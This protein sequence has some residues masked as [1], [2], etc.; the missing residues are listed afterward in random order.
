M[1]HMDY[2][3]CPK[4]Q[5]Q[6]LIVRS[7]TI[8]EQ[9]RLLLALNENA[10]EPYRTMI[11]LSLFTDTRP[12]EICVLEYSKKIIKNNRISITKTTTRDINHK[13][14]LGKTTKTHV[15][16]QNIKINDDIGVY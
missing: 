3:I 5:K 8:Y 15:E 4:S 14:I 11:I 2:I 9:Q 6:A 12:G 1:N 13:Y 16:T 7:L 10:K